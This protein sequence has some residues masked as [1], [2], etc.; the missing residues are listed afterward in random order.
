MRRTGKSFNDA[1]NDAVRA[2]L[3]RR[4]EAAEAEPFEVRPK[5]LGLRP[6]LDYSNVADLLEIAEGPA[7][8]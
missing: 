3:S 2:G 1:V 6:G 5:A 8:R 4:Q 7:H